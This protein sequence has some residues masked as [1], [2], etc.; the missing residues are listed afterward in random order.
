MDEVERSGRT[1]LFVSHNMDA[2]ARLC[3]TTVWLDGGRV[4]TIGP[5]ERVIAE[6]LRATAGTAT[7]VSIEL[8]ATAPAQVVGVALTDAAGAAQSVLTTRAT[9]WFVLDIVVNEPLPGLDVSCLLATRAGVHILEE[10]LGDAVAGSIATPGRYR[11]RC[12]LP[13]ILTP[14]EYVLSVWFGTAYENL[15]LHED[16]IGFTVEGDDL[17]RLR[18]LVKIGARWDVERVDEP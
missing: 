1:V 10:M 3:A 18:R 13:P 2:I 16:V 4:R 9:G 15:E 12:E 14:G 5:T 17:G 7:G 8:D 11:V 6:Y